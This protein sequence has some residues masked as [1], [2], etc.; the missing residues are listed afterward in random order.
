M[1]VKV[2]YMGYSR[3]GKKEFSI[4][5]VLRSKILKMA[6]QANMDG[7]GNGGKK[8]AGTGLGALLA[9]NVK[10]VQD[11]AQPVTDVVESTI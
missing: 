9:K 3:G 6:M 11:E 1:I 4:K 8:A 5:N 7:T 10:A 2:L